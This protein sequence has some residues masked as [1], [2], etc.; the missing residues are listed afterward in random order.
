MNSC[1][2]PISSTTSLL[3]LGAFIVIIGP[4][5]ILYRY[6]TPV[7]VCL[8]AIVPR[9][10]T[11][12]KLT[13][14]KRSNLGRTSS[15]LYKHLNPVRPCRWERSTEASNLTMSKLGRTSQWMHCRFPGPVLIFHHAIAPHIVIPIQACIPTIYRLRTLGRILPRHERIGRISYPTRISTLAAFP[16]TSKRLQFRYRGLGEISTNSAL[17]TQLQSRPI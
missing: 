2:A 10:S 6:L 16:H 1:L 17:P 11:L 3:R 7:R 14:I 4:Q 12:T 9:P 8:R 15:H 13:R 5:Q